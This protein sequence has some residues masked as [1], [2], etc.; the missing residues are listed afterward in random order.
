[1]V[2]EVL[3]LAEPPVKLATV[4]VKVVYHIYIE[5]VGAMVVEGDVVDVEEVEL[6]EVIR[7]WRGRLGVLEVLL[8][9]AT[10]FKT[11]NW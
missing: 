1:M 7:W 8:L 5:G 2:L 4:E 6:R 3:S 9:A 10:P 11:C